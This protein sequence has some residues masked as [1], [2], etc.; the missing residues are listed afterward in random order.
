MN[1]LCFSGRT[2]GL[3]VAGTLQA[4]CQCPRV[5]EVCSQALS[6]KCLQKVLLKR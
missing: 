3:T 6:P 5:G 1:I 2:T 4:V